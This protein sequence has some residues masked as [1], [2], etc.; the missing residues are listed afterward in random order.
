[1]GVTFDDY[2]YPYRPPGVTTDFPDTSTWRGYANGMARDDWRRANINHFV[3]SVYTG[4]K[5]EK[6]WV[7]FG[8]SPFGI[9]RP[10]N[11]PSVKG[12][13]AYATLYADSRLWLSNGWVDYLAPQLYWRVD[14]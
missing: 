6:P 13:D 3:Q 2:F 5:T 9:W 7:K 11:P 4:I 1:D 12:L 10:A 8:V 14:A